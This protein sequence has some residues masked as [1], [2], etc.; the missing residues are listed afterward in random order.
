ML[1]RKWQRAAKKLFSELYQISTS[2]IPKSQLLKT[3][4]VGP[5][6]PYGPLKHSADL[7]RVESWVVLGFEGVDKMRWL[8]EFELLQF[9]QRL[10]TPHP[11][12][13]SPLD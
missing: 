3:G 8:W 1:G 4:G 13:T 10:D 5:T 9:E 7:D 11:K 12:N 2:E 6:R